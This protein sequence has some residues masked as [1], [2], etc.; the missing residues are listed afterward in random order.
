MKASSLLPILVLGAAVAV[1]QDATPPA[2]APADA[3]AAR[4]GRPR[5]RPGGDQGPRGGFRGG[6][7]GEGREGPRGG[8]RGGPGGADAATMADMEARF[9]T[10]MITRP[11]MATELGLSE[12]TVETLKTTFDDIDTRIVA[13]QEELD[14]A[15]KAQTE[16]LKVA[17]VD[18][19]AVMDAVEKVWD[20][21]S[22]IAALQTRKLI[23]ILNTLTPE[24][25][26]KAREML[27]RPGGFGGG[28]FGG[29]G[30]GGGF[31]RGEGRRSGPPPA[32]GNPPAPPAPP[33]AP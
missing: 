12:E 16:L 24:Q 32:D 14:A 4:E 30:F 28:G 31:G 29:G 11:Q 27:R 6:P 10:R 25:V 3:P 5:R 23:A 13:L 18:E 7:G 9:F 1:A 22:R 17:P 2:A 33:A 26:A 21:R 20:V 19:A 8:F 15:S